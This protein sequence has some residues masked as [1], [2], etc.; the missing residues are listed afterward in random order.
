MSVSTSLL[1]NYPTALF[2]RLPIS[3]TLSLSIFSGTVSRPACPTFQYHSIHSQMF[4]RPHPKVTLIPPTSDNP[5]FTLRLLPTFKLTLDQS[6]LMGSRAKLSD[7]PKV[8]QMIEERIRAAIATRFDEYHI[9]L[10]GIASR[11]NGQR[12]AGGEGMRRR[13]VDVYVEK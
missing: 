3:L 6:S 12:T 7:V 8:H 9:M 4:V 2:A 5:S 13:T 11:D 10:P 1:F